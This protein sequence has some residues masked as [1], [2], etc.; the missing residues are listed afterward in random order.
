MNKSELIT[1][2]SEQTDLPKETAKSAVDTMID[3]MKQ[4]LIQGG[5]I[6]IRGFGSFEV[7]EYKGYQGR[8]PRT[9]ELVDV[10]PKK[11]PVFKC[12]LDLEEKVNQE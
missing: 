4:Q 1:A 6:D 10:K 3:L 12:G 11:L 9:G 7:K 2:L 8:N 5:R